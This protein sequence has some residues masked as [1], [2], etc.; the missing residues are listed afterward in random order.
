MSR[1]I[2][3]KRFN[4]QQ[5]TRRMKTLK[6]RGTR[7]VAVLDKPYAVAKVLAGNT[8]VIATEH[9]RQAKNSNPTAN[10][11]LS[12][13]KI[14]KIRQRARIVQDFVIKTWCVDIL[15]YLFF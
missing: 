8:A 5:A 7:Q 15:F 14:K 11:R 3:R 2:N 1:C 4:H 9:Q 10:I 6:K 13:K 12:A